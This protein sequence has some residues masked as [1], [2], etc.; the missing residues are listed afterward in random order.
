[1]SYPDGETYMCQCGTFR[2][3]THTKR[4]RDCGLRKEFGKFRW[5][6]QWA[7]IRWRNYWELVSEKEDYRH[8][9]G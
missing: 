9:W 2:S 8:M 1:M 3:L 7:Y 4:C 6:R 5:F